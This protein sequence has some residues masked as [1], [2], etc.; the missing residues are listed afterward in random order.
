MEV[1]TLLNENKTAGNY[2]VGFN[3]ANLP[4]GAYFYR[5]EADNY[6][7]TKKMLLLK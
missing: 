2:I 1:A 5:L 7:E 6:V 4:S 3:A